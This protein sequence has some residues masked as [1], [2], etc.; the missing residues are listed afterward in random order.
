M[1]KGTTEE[2]PALL[3]LRS[4]KKNLSA[5]LKVYGINKSWYKYF[6]ITDLRIII[7]V[8]F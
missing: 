7:R 8:P 6:L 5:K 4:V 3:F 1:C 2:T